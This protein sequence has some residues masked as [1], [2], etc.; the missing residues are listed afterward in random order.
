MSDEERPC[1]R[2]T[3]EELVELIRSS[4]LA[5]REA[6]FALAQIESRLTRPDWTVQRDKCLS[7]I[8][9]VLIRD[10]EKDG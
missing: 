6:N 3:H 5:A 2:F 1:G 7:I 4:S 9:G 10:G 8:R